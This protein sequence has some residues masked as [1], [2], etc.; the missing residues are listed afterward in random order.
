MRAPAPAKAGGYMVGELVG[1]VLCIGLYTVR[2]HLCEFPKGY[3]LAGVRIHADPGYESL[4]CN[5]D[6]TTL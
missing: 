5:T 3:E 2:Y 6:F 4:T 1:L